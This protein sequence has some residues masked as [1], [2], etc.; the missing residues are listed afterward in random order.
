MSGYIEI[1]DMPDL[2]AVTDTSKI[3]GERAGSGVF[4][5][6]ALLD[7]VGTGMSYTADDGTSRQMTDKLGDT[8]SVRDFGATGDGATNDTAAINAALATFNGYGGTLLFPLGSYLYTPGLVV[9]TSVTLQGQ[10]AILVAAGA[11]AVNCILL[12]IASGLRNLKLIAQSNAVAGSMVY[13]TG[14][15]ARVIDCYM[16]NYYVGITF[17]GLSSAAPLIGAT[18]HDVLMNGPP[19]ASA[20]V[21]IDHFGGFNFTDLL[22]SGTTAP[23]PAASV[24]ISRGDTGFLSRMNCTLHG[25]MRVAPPALGATIAMRFTDIFCDLP[26]NIDA[27]VFAPGPGGS[28]VNTLISNGWFSGSNTGNGMSVFAN[29]DGASGLISGFVMNNCN[30]HG[31]S[32][33]GLSIGGTGVDHLVVTGATVT[34]S[35]ASGVFV[36][37]GANISLVGVQ[38]GALGGNAGNIGNGIGL[39]GALDYYIVQGCT[40]NGNTGGGLVDGASGTHKSLTGNI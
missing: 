4:G 37:G 6:P 12:G 38:S 15:N 40:T 7:Y 26:G 9:P 36:N 30:F 2:G 1:D 29:N 8:K 5:M 10:G 25:S 28:I 33:T 19:N 13:A 34:G 27:A 31:N 39:A 11:P 35:G 24:I 20:A 14:N 21:M 23:Y 22:I 18:L 32:S 17:Q 3:V 16:L